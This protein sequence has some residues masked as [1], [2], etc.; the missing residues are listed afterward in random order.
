MAKIF[1][2]DHGTNRT[3]DAFQQWA[4]SEIGSPF[5]RGGLVEY[6][7]I[8]HIRDNAEYIFAPR[9]EMMTN[10]VPKA[11]HFETLFEKY[12]ATQPGGD[13][14][15]LQVHWG[16]TIE[17]KS[18][19]ASANWRLPVK[20]RWNLWD[21]G[22]R[23]NEKIFPAQYYILGQMAAPPRLSGDDIIFPDMQFYV[24]S[25]RSLEELCAKE[26][27]LDKRW[28]M[29]FKEF[30]KNVNPVTTDGLADEL[31]AVQRIEIRSVIQKNS[32]EWQETFVPSNS[33]KLR[34]PF[35][36]EYGGEELPLG[37]Y[38]QDEASLTWS[39]AKEIDFKW[40]RD[41]SM[42][43]RDWEAVGFKYDNSPK[44]LKHFRKG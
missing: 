23:N 3:F 4:Y 31:Q 36:L 28:W 37:Y 18:T 24:R 16:T 22:Y 7:V 15:D 9:L 35:R 39:L 42:S 19:A 10:Q 30:T 21:G 11:S 38:E 17:I 27:L 26:K 5:I 43:W 1:I 6:I 25:G 13:V 12:Y 14:Y 8:Q 33:S 41:I 44:P 20:S 34:V 2:G 40:T 29:T 32:W